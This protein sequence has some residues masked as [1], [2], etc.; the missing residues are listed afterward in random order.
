MAIL[1]N[2][3]N[4]MRKSV[5][6]SSSITSMAIEPKRKRYTSMLTLPMPAAMTGME[7]RGIKPNEMPDMMPL[8]NPSALFVSQPLLLA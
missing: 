7:N 6:L 1:Q 3:E 2:S 8:I 5:F 4:V